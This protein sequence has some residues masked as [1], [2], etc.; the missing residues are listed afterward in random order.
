MAG[1]LTSR[2]QPP[3]TISLRYLQCGGLYENP[4]VPVDC[5]DPGV[6]R[7]GSRYVMTCTSGGAADAFPIRVSSDLVHWTLVGTIFPAASKPAWASGDFWAPEIHKVGGGYVAYFTARNRLDGRLSVGAAHATAA[8]GPFHDLGQPLVHDGALGMIDPTEFTDADGTPYLAWKGDG[9]AMGQPTPLYGQQ[10]AL[11]GLSLVGARKTLLTND[12]ASWEGGVIEGPW[13]VSRGGQYFLFYSGNAYFNGSYAVGVAN[14]SA[15]LGPYHKA[16]APILTTRGVWVGPGHCS[17]VEGP[18]GETVMV[19]HAWRA[20]HV[21]G[22][23]DGRLTL[24]D[25][26]QWGS[27]PTVPEAPSSRSR[28]LP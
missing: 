25:E 21:N 9:N 19:Y 12:P 1:N 10:L 5:P 6:L 28:P 4:V 11:D 15:P 26:V 2:V 24:V 18:A 17:V 14:A 20:G 7:D 27:G 22:P 8:T 16:G 3:V 13:V 23:G